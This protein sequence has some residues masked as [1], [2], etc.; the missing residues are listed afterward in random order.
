MHPWQILASRPLLDRQ[1]WLSV[2]EEDVQLPNGLTIDGYLRARGRDY[3]MIFA[4]LED[5]TAPLVRQYKQGVGRPMYDLPAGYLDAPDESP[6]VAA[7][8]ELLEE[9]GLIAGR[10]E[11][12]GHLVIDTNRGDTRAH[13]YLALDAQ[14]NGRQ[15]LDP[16]EAIEV[17][18]H[19]PDDLRR[20]VLNQ[21]I[22]SLASVAG[23]M[24]AL[25][26]LGIR[27]QETGSRN[28]ETGGGNAEG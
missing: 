21:E 4:L 16:T 20:M 8:R 14:P 23:I 25:A 28:Q 11:S 9:T 2:W 10:W 12:L 15:H 24:L 18:Y 5:G 19:R 26:A 6:L 13:L 22:D 27:G 7:Q 1:P 17:S 3:A